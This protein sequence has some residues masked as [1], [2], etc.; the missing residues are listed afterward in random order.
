[1]LWYPTHPTDCEHHAALA[2]TG[3]LSTSL[4]NH[5]NGRSTKH[6]APSIG[7]FQNNE[8]YCDTK[9]LFT[10]KYLQRQFITFLSTSPSARP[11]NKRCNNSLCSQTSTITRKHLQI[12]LNWKPLNALHECLSITETK[13]C[14]TNLT[15][16]WPWQRHTL[17]SIFTVDKSRLDAI[18]F[19]K[20][21]TIPA[22]CTQLL[23]SVTAV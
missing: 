17:T 23:S 6:A 4:T 18:K 16:N 20:N 8:K 12:I 5:R 21:Y 22:L 10:W 3:R 14:L 13:L 1:M 11:R 2:S 19:T 9:K 15:L 7:R